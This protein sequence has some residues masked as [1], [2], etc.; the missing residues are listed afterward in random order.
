MVDS[1]IVY[2]MVYSRYLFR[3]IRKERERERV[4]ERERERER[5]IEIKRKKERNSEKEKR[6]AEVKTKGK[7]TVVKNCGNKE[8]RY[9]Q[10]EIKQ[11]VLCHFL[12]KI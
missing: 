10:R 3:K 12:S 9:K 6:R 5:K 7:I 1:A 4:R 8:I 2:T 11:K